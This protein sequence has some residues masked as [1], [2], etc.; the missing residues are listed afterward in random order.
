[1]CF[2]RRRTDRSPAR[3]E[4]SLWR[5]VR[6]VARIEDVRLHDLRHTFASPAVMQRVPLPVVARL[7]GHSGDRMALRYAHVGDRET[8][9]AA[10]RIGVRIA[11][12]LDGAG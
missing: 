1:M 7:L 12:L 2:R 9:A 3:P 5:K 10:E 6:Q 8:E 4:L 11:K